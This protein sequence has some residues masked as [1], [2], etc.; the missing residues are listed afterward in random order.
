MQNTKKNTTWQT[1]TGMQVSRLRL[2]RVTHPRTGVKFEITVSYIEV[3]K[4]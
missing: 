2:P 1:I 3:R 4:N